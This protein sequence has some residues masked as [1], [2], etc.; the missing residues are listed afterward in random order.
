MQCL[1][2]IEMCKIKYKERK[3]N[4]KNPN[5]LF[6]GYNLKVN[7]ISRADIY[8]PVFTQHCT[9]GSSHTMIEEK[10]RK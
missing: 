7:S 6:Y 10:I 3:K 1:P 4:M 8:Y 9:G 5:R 2:I